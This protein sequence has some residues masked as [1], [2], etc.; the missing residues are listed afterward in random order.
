MIVE[1]LDKEWNVNDCTYKQRRELHALNAKVWWEGKQDVG[2][3][4]ELLDK[5]SEIAGLGENDFEDMR[6]SDI[7]IV[8]QTIFI[9]YLGLSKKA[10]GD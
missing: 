8:L 9:E 5:V 6:M 3:Y 7:D 1:A 10:I 4:Y 2:A